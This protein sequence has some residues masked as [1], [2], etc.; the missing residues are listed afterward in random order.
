MRSLV[1]N[2]QIKKRINTDLFTDGRCGLLYKGNRSKIYSFERGITIEC[3]SLQIMVCTQL[4][5]F[6]LLSLSQYFNENV[7]PLHIP[8][9]LILRQAASW[10]SFHTFSEQ[11]IYSCLQPPVFDLISF[12]GHFLIRKDITGFTQISSSTSSALSCLQHRTR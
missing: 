7:Q 8:V 10:S 5:L 9:K 1:I 11:G 2:F 12:T 3:W 4:K 6:S